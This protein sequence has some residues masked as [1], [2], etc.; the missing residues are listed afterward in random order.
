MNVAEGVVERHR[1]D[2][3]H[4]GL[5]HVTSDAPLLQF[6]ENLSDVDR[7]GERELTASLLRVRGSD[8]ADVRFVGLGGVLS[9]IMLDQVLQVTCQQEGLLAQCLH[10]GHVKHL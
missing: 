9:V 2:P 1:S 3:Q 10:T 8:D 4:T 7:E 6:L 5:S